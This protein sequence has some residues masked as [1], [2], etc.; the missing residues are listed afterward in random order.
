MVNWQNLD[1]AN[2]KGGA[3]PKFNAKLW[4][5]LTYHGG[6]HNPSLSHT[7][8]FLWCVSMKQ[9]QILLFIS[10]IYYI[11]IEAEFPYLW[12]EGGSQGLTRKN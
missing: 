7:S 9:W 4:S 2:L 1:G 8:V 11:C 10:F 12:G 6:S 5:E 3:N